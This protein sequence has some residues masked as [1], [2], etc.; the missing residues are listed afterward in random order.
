MIDAIQ[1]YTKAIELQHDLAVGY[2]NRGSAYTKKGEI[3]RAIEA[4][5]QSDTTAT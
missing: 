4:Y 2:N 3:E 1:D 5:Y